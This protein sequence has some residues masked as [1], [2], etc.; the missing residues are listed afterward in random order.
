M[1]QDANGN[2]TALVGPTGT[3]LEHFVYS[4][5]GAVSTINA[6]YT[7]TATDT[8]GMVYLFQDGRIDPL[9][10]LYHFGSPGRDYSP[11]DGKWMEQDYDGYVN[12][13]NL[14][15]LELSRIP[16]MES[17]QLGWR[18]KRGWKGSPNLVQS[19][20]MGPVTG[21][22][23]ACKTLTTI[24]RRTSSRPQPQ[25]QPRQAAA[26]VLIW[27]RA[28]AENLTLGLYQ[29]PC[30]NPKAQIPGMMAAFIITGGFV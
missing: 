8:S 15:Q 25:P 22:T 7:A 26:G 29:D 21:A 24:W 18:T 10:G 19:I 6:A 9:T 13:S 16:S 2:V 20:L 27:A 17:I 30:P 23:T 14:Y 3:V 28:T 1:E 5:Y 4:S 11:T 12:G